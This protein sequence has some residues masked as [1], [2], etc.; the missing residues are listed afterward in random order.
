MDATIVLAVNGQPRT[1]TTDPE[2]SLLEVLREDLGLTG[3]K[4]GC[5]QGLCGACRR[6]AIIT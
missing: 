4:Y 3:P 1:V 5:G 2:R 6:L